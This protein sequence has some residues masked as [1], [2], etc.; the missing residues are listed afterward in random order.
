MPVGEKAVKALSKLGQAAEFVQNVYR[1]CK[2]LLAIGAGKAL[3]DGCGASPKLD[4]GDED[5]G[6]IVADAGEHDE[7]IE[8]FIDALAKHRHFER[9]KDPPAV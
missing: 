4:N 3:L 6:V 1:H 2:P 8:K 9:E 7:A 5:P